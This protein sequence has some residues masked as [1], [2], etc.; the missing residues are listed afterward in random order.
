MIALLLSLL[1]SLFG[2]VHH[3]DVRGTEAAHYAPVAPALKPNPST[4]TA[5]PL[6]G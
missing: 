1:T 2:A 6:A 4:L 3:A 5:H